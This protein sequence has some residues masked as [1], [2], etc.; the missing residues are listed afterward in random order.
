MPV[1]PGEALRVTGPDHVPGELAFPAAGQQPFQR[2]PDDVGAD[3]DEQGAGHQFQP[4]RREHAPVPEPPGGQAAPPPAGIVGPGGE[5]PVLPGLPWL[6][7]QPVQQQRQP[8]AAAGLDPGFRQGRG[9]RVDQVHHLPAALPGRGPGLRCPAGG[10]ALGQRRPGA[11]GGLGSGVRPA[12]RPG[13]RSPGIPAEQHVH[14][15]RPVARGRDRRLPRSGLADLLGM[16]GQD[17]A[18]HVFLTGRQVDLRSREPG[19]PEDGLHSVSGSDES[20]AIR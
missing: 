1:Q 18:D 12:R 2:R 16:M 11:A 3:Q 17:P 20:S 5:P 14:R 13:P 6:F 15:L 10:I 19:M 9:S 7:F 8:A 4:R